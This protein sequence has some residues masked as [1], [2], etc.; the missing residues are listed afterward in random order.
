M[1]AKDGAYQA[2]APEQQSS[3]TVGRAETRYKQMEQGREPF[4]RRARQCSELT[5]PW[6]IPPQDWTGTQDLYTPFQGIGAKGT[7]HL[8]SKLMLSLFPP[9]SPF[10]RLKLDGKAEDAAKQADPKM[11][12]D[13]EAK[14]AD[15]ERKFSAEIETQQYRPYLAQG[16]KHMIV[17]GNVL[18]Y[19]PEKADETGASCRVFRLDKYV[20]KRSPSGRV[21]EIVVKEGVSPKALDPEFYAEVAKIAGYEGDDKL[22]DMY[23][24]IYLEGKVYRICQE[25]KG[26]TVPGSEGSYP[27]DKLPW[28]A[29]RWHEIDGED[30]GRGYVEDL[31]GDLQTTEGLTQAIFEGSS[32]AAKLLA[33]VN[34]NGS[35]T[36]KDVTEAPN[37]SA[38]YGNAEDVT[39]LRVDKQN[40]FQVAQTTASAVEKRLAQGFLL[41]S[42]AQRSGER[43]TAEEWRFMI[44]ELEESLGGIYSVLAHTLQLPL[45][46]IIIPRMEKEGKIPTLPKGSVRPVIVTGMEA[47]GRGQDVAKLRDMVGEA[48]KTW[49]PEI[50]MKYIHVDDYFKRLATGV[51]IDPTGLI[52]TEEELQAQEQQEAQ[53]AQTQQIM[54]MVQK[55]GPAGIKAATEQKGASNG[56]GD[57]A[58]EGGNPVPQSGG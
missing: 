36:L 14:L 27:A 48:I 6:L 55:L 41:N 45:A 7:N 2:G 20:I 11:K 51:G 32:A 15:I 30:Y 25:V 58:Q 33:L 47:L 21:L 38:R 10:I 52:K 54:E 44:Q 13:V 43:V 35:T 56:P 24:Y 4:L 28:L 53:A 50:A 18:Y 19:F 3:P 29:M 31:L 37:G 22:C 9:N 26:L 42:S 1:A 57:T 46:K 17:G 12:D 49:G 5:V 34:P 40:D 16:L 23:T 39:F 8:T